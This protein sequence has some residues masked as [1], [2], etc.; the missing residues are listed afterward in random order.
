MR[1][2][3][4]ISALVIYIVDLSGFTD[5]WKNFLWRHFKTNTK[6]MKPFDCSQCMTWWVGLAYLAL[7]GQ[8]TLPMIC[9]AAALAF[10]SYP[11]GQIFIFIKE[12]LN[13]IID[14]LTGW[15]LK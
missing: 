2:L 11:I 13:F 8:F 1:N 3:L 5:S 6:S 10:L 9:L 12:G 15:L 7:S 14:K 4:L